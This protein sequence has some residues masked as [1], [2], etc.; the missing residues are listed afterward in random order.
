MD[1][2]YLLVQSKTYGKEQD[3][4]MFNDIQSSRSFMTEIYEFASVE[5]SLPHASIDELWKLETIGIIGLAKKKYDQGVLEHF[6][7]TVTKDNKS[8]STYIALK[9]WR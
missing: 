1:A 3:R 5:E 7:N 2:Q 9:K 6:T 4:A 8:L